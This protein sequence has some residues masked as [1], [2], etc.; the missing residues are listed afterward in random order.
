MDL[1]Y[2]PNTPET[3]KMVKM[4]SLCKF[5]YGPTLKRVNG[6]MINMSVLRFYTEAMKICNEYLQMK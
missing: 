1:D 6:F 5:K 4:T 2:A 3:L